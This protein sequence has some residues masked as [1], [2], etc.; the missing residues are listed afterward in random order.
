MCNAELEE[1]RLHT[2]GWTGTFEKTSLYA[3]NSKTVCY[4]MILMTLLEEIENFAYTLST[5][6]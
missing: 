3:F 6:V 1:I 4:M 2:T 5:L